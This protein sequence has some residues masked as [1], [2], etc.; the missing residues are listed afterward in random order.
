MRFG[1]LGP[2]QVATGDGGQVRVPEAKVRALLAILLAH[3][4]SP[5]PVSRLFDQIWGG[6]DLPANPANALQTKVSQLRRAFESAEPG[7]GRLVVHRASGYALRVEPDAVDLG[8]FRALV[9]RARREADPKARAALLADALALWRG[10]ALAEF[11]DRPFALAPVRRW[12]EERLVAVEERAQARL[13]L[14]HHGELTGELAQLVAEHPLR[15]RLRA[16]YVRALYGAGRQSEALD[17]LAELRARLV[18]ERGLDLSPELADLRQAILAH[19]GSLRP[20]EPRAPDNLPARV[21]ELVGRDEAIGRVHA[22]L[23]AHRL[24]TL[25]GVGGVGKTA[26]AFESAR[27]LGEGFPDGVRVV[28]LADIASASGAAALGR[29]VAT[30]L[31]VRDGADLARFLRD[32]RMLILLDNCEHVI[33]DVGR[34]AGELLGSAAGLRILATSREPLG[35]AGEALLDV[36]PLEV[37]AA[38]RLFTARAAGFGV[39][40]QDAATVAAICTRLDGIPL[41][42][43]LAAA[44]VRALGT[45]ELLA[46]LDNRFELLVAGRRDAPTRQRTLRATIEWSWRL[47]GHTERAVLRRLAVHLGGCTL[48]AAE[49]VCAGDGVDAAEVLGALARLVDCS[50]VTVA[51]DKAGG[52]R[53]YRLLESVA[54][55]CVERMRAAGELDRVLERHERHYLALAERADPGL[56]GG[57]Q[58]HWLARLDAERANLRRALDTAIAR[59]AP[60]AAL[61]LVN[62]QAWYWFLRGRLGE[63]ERSAGAALRSGGSESLRARAETYRAAVALLRGADPDGADAAAW[64]RIEGRRDR[65]MSRWFLVMARGTLGEVAAEHA[66]VDEVLA[67]LA[68]VGDDWGGAVALTERASRALARGDL[69]AAGRL[70]S[71]GVERFTALGDDWG[72]LQASFVLGHVAEIVGDYRR[73]ER[74]HRDGLLA[75]QALGLWAEA[76]YQLSWLGRTALLRGEH[77][78]ARELHERAMRTAEEHGFVPG[79]RYAETGLALGA[80]RQGRFEDAQRHLATV[81]GWFAQRE[82]E[83][84]NALILAELGFLAEQRG[85]PVGALE[86]H[87]DGLRIARGVDDPRAVA[88]ALEGIAGAHSLAGRHEDAARLLG[89]G[90]ALRERTGAPLPAAERGDVDRIAARARAG[91]GADRFSARFDQG[92]ALAPRAVVDELVDAHPA[93]ARCLGRCRCSP[94]LGCNRNASRAAG[95]TASAISANAIR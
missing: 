50:L 84:G 91:A 53:R 6:A 49:A 47:L 78:R 75:A 26:L 66:E 83:P 29:M 64:R 22:A 20:A 54:D 76:S 9:E 4:G 73:R 21:T 41:A 34:L 86:L 89:A 43:E 52:R 67:E 42:L 77:E 94:A 92:R 74:I 37:P 56:R 90:A 36:P 2:L 60:D 13:V 15:E 1:V 39:D 19:D 24:V 27:R 58:R 38:V 18:E 70:A 79:V 48:D 95:S 61:R 33:D 81:R 7:A 80:R 32:K 44:R 12:E 69:A 14:E 3:Q 87:L 23:D 40:V 45:D 63:A 88:L 93:A 65:A 8:R 85:D 57:D 31:D 11:A 35:I 10:P 71:R 59:R 82:L 5:V 55:Y 46:R 62:A 72:R 28:E 25:V 68:A 17:S 51:D 16:A 30:V